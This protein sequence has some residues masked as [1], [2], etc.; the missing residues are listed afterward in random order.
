MADEAKNVIDL[1]NDSRGELQEIRMGGI[2]GQDG[3][4]KVRGCCWRG[5]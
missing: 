5:L 3:G 2:R 4:T 1:S